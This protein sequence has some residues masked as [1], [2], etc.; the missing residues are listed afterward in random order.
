MTKIFCLLNLF[1]TSII[2][3]QNSNSISIQRATIGVGASIISYPTSSFTAVQSIGQSSVIGNFKQS[4]LELRQ[5]FIQPLDFGVY[6]FDKIN[7]TAS[8]FPN[9][10]IN[11]F[12]ITFNKDIE[13]PK[14]VQIFNINGKLVF[15]KMFSEKNNLLIE[16]E[17]L[18][19]STYILIL[20]IQ[21]QII[22]KKIIKLN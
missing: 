2:V 5:G 13:F 1:F 9:P 3:A 17:N 21:N 11:T 15:N 12:Q 16:V 19:I 18:E 7:Y 8:I 14:N 20:S 6:S 10:F 4:N 22:S